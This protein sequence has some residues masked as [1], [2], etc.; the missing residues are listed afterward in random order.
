MP[1]IAEKPKTAVKVVDIESVDSWIAL[2]DSL[3]LEDGWDDCVHWL[4]DSEHCSGDITSEHPEDWEEV[5]D[6]QEG[7][8]SGV[9][10]GGVR[11]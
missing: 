6:N 8:C 7:C 11:S 4:Q 5:V 3:D 1:K 10:A 2:E 9:S